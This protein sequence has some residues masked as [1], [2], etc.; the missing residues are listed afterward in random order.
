MN[1]EKY[2]AEGGGLV[3]VHAANNSWGDWPEYN[4]MIGIGGWG[5][6]D[7]NSGYS[8]YYDDAGV[9]HRETP[10]K[11]DA[12]SHG[13]QYEGIITTRAPEHPI[14]KGIPA[15]WLHARDEMYD[16][17]VG[18]AE[19]MTVLMRCVSGF[20]FADHFCYHLRFLL[21]YISEDKESYSGW[22]LRFTPVSHAMRS[23]I[24]R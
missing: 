3:V 6:R 2:M 23:L 10:P 16:R 14:M 18:P 7:E 11:G 15:S 24:C 8:V 1:F 21:N 4:K 20:G 5:G 13:D 12:G 17:L 9:L 22:K 19:N